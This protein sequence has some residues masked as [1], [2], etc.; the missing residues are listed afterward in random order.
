MEVLALG[1]CSS[2]WLFKLALSFFLISSF[3]QN[4]PI[5]RSYAWDNAEYEMYD[6]VEEINKNFYEVLGVAQV[7]SL[8]NN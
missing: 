8:C 2:R 5:G 6:L 1:G 3:W 7:S 4:G